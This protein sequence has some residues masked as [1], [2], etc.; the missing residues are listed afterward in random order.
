MTRLA[1]AVIGAN[2]GDEGKGLAVDAL[3]AALAA[4]GRPVTVVRSN[5]GAQAGHG[6][7]HESG[8]HHVFHHVGAGTFSGAATHLSRHFV[9]HPMMLGT[10]LDALDRLGAPVPQITIDPRAQVTTPW[11][12]AINQALELSRGGARHGSTGL[13]FGETLERAERGLSFAAADL[14]SR[15]LPERLREIRDRWLPARLSEVGIDPETGPLADVLTGRQDL[16]T[17]FLEDCRRFRAAVLPEPD[18][19]LAER[20][21]VVFEAAQGLRLDMDSGEFPHVTRSHT[22]LANMLAIAA[23][24]GIEAL[25]PLYM[26]RAYATRHG[27]GPLPHEKPGADGIGRIEWARITDRTNAENCWQGTI[28]AAPLDTDLLASSIARDLD[29]ARGT[30]V[31]IDP[32]LGVTCLDQL[33]PSAAIVA[34]GSERKIRAGA[35]PALIAERTGLPLRLLSFGPA[36]GDVRLED[37]RRIADHR[38][39]PRLSPRRPGSASPQDAGARTPVASDAAGCDAPGCQAP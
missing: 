23:E 10:E 27:A 1:H 28:R 20:A 5:G 19:K 35:L 12:M 30:G 14:W 29:L 25:R 17:P 18:R 6:V 33:S 24:A 26:T 34:E 15:D 39:A 32:G 3:A 9:A 8:A 31:A 16:L 22:G 2:W 11:D 7:R 13:G 38:P 36:R 21:A 37:L 4:T